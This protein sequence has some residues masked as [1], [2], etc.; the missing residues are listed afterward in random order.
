MPPVDKGGEIESTPDEDESISRRNSVGSHDKAVFKPARRNSVPH[1]MPLNHA[2]ELMNS[3]NP[4]ANPPAEVIVTDCSNNTSPDPQPAK[5]EPNP[6]DESLL[7]SRASLATLRVSHSRSR[8]RSPT[9][10]PAMA[11]ISEDTEQD[12]KGPYY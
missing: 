12:F 1:T 11:S 4:N 10:Q 6:P 8:S 2:N 7:S 9:P 3:E 5:P